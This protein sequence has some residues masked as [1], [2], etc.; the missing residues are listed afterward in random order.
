MSKYAESLLYNLEDPRRT[1]SRIYARR[2]MRKG[3]FRD[4]R[5]SFTRGARVKSRYRRRYGRNL[6]RGTMLPSSLKDREEVT[7]RTVARL[8]TTPRAQK[9]LRWLSGGDKY[10]P[11]TPIERLK[12]R[13]NRA[14]LSRARAKPS[15]KEIKRWRA[16]PEKE[17]EEAMAKALDELDELDDIWGELQ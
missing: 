1:N 6:P 15:A 2:H 16:D 8:G 10:A 3:A 11:L 12:A 4:I 14:K 9:I 17:I 7:A 5:D 13:A